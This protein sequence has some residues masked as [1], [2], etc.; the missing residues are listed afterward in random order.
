MC[1]IYSHAEGFAYRKIAD[2]GVILPVGLRRAE[3]SDLYQLSEVGSFIWE[4][5]DG[6][7]TTDD[8]VASITDEYKVDEK[9]AQSDLDAFLAK[10]EAKGVIVAQD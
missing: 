5:I 6:R 7:R 3:S 2:M 10:L 1:R 9:Q 4:N 8:L